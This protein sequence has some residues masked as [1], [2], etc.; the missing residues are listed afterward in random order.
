MDDKTKVANQEKSRLTASEIWLKLSENPEYIKIILKEGVA[1]RLIKDLFIKQCFQIQRMLTICE[2]IQISPEYGLNDTENKK[3]RKASHTN[4]NE[5]VVSLDLFSLPIFIHFRT[6][7]YTNTI[8]PGTNLKDIETFT[9]WSE[10]AAMCD[11]CE[12]TNGKRSIMEHVGSVCICV[13]PQISAVKNAWVNIIEVAYEFKERTEDIWRFVKNKCIDELKPLLLSHRNK[14]LLS[15]YDTLPP[16]EGPRLRSHNFST[17]CLHSLDF[18]RCNSPLP[19]ACIAY[20]KSFELT[21]RGLPLCWNTSLSL[22]ITAVVLD[23][24]VQTELCCYHQRPNDAPFRRQIVEYNKAVW[25]IDLQE[26]YSKLRG[27][28]QSELFQGM[29]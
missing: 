10:V 23:E 11:F 22:G 5:L 29:L 28:V 14:S 21:H 8:P 15:C 25:Q 13:V 19:I 6:L 17:C 18:H 24:H 1:V 16:G 26:A 3:K 27:E 4:T 20:S 7:L 2:P 12:F 9:L